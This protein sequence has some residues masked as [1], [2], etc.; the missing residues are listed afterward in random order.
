[1]ST[2]VNLDGDGV[3]TPLATATAAAPGGEINDVQYKSGPNSF[4]GSNYFSV[5]IG[6]SAVNL[7][8]SHVLIHQSTDPDSVANATVIFSSTLDLGES[9]VYVK[10]DTETDE[11]VAYKRARKLALIL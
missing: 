9:G 11:L 10:N 4:G 2:D 5:D 7:D 3:Y 6:N 8:G 1:M